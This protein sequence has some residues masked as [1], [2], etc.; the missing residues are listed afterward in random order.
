[1]YV[2]KH[3][4][5]VR[6]PTRSPGPRG[7]ATADIHQRAAPG[8]HHDELVVHFQP[9]LDLATGAPSG[10]EAL[11]RWQHPERGLLAPVHF[12]PTAEQTSLIDSLTETVL[13]KSLD[14]VQNWHAS[15]LL[16]GVSVN[17]SPHSLTNSHLLRTVDRLLDLYGLDGHWL[18]LEITEEVFLGDDDGALSVLRDLKQRGVTIAIDDFGS[19]YSSMSY[20]QR[21]PADELKI[22]R[23]LVAELGKAHPRRRTEQPV[24]VE[25]GPVIVRSIIEM[26]HRLGLHV[27]AEGVET[28]DM[29]ATLTSAG[30]DEAQGFVIA[31]PMPA[32]SVLAWLVGRSNAPASLQQTS[33]EAPT[34][35]PGP[36]STPVPNFAT[37]PLDGYEP[38]VGT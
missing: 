2:A 29:L 27:V 31:R 11:V 13:D 25:Y 21:L 22:D 35:A 14:A 26:G 30:C 16:V 36:S 20:L 18:C 19:G 7:P 15:G 37:R 10:V 3:P 28:P 4:D 33:G 38:R 8:H 23:S 12:I 34:K 17:V 1:M 6:R 32:E 5:A 9:K 24:P